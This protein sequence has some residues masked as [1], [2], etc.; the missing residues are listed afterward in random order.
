MPTLWDGSRWS[1]GNP[2]PV[3][4]VATVVARKTAVQPSRRLPAT[5]PSTTTSPDAIPARLISMWTTVNVSSVIPRTTD[6]FPS[7]RGRGPLG[8]WRSMRVS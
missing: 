1:N 8:R 2:N 6:H 4:L 3:T 5:R 7:M